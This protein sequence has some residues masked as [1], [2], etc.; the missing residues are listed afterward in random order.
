MKKASSK[1]SVRQESKGAGSLREATTAK[2]KFLKN[3]G[4]QERA[5]PGAEVISESCHISEKQEA[6]PPPNAA[7]KE[8][9]LAGLP[10][11]LLLAGADVNPK[12]IGEE[13]NL[14]AGA[15]SNPEMENMT[16][17]RE[18]GK[19]LPDDNAVKNATG[20]FSNLGDGKLFLIENSA[21]F[22][23]TSSQEEATIASVVKLAV[24]LVEFNSRNETIKPFT[25]WK[26]HL[27]LEEAAR[28]PGQL[29]AAELC[30]KSPAGNP[31]FQQLGKNCSQVERNPIQ[32]PAV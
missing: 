15:E 30:I 25:R 20:Q 21:L 19:S 28:K 29:N 6:T 16:L 13:L 8:R 4:E 31:V 12:P 32:V 18:D 24:A 26:N 7:E 17:P 3:S 9:E 11:P 2:L 27:L 23:T 1:Q 5:G 14:K 10:Y 22:P